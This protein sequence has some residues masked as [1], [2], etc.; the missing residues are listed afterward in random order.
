MQDINHH[1]CSVR[2]PFCLTPFLHTPGRPQKT[3]LHKKEGPE[4]T[5][6]PLPQKVSPS[7]M[8]VRW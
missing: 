8:T 2:R 6:R 5:S 7:Q 1:I 4:N 3:H